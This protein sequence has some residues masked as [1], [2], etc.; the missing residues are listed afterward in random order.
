VLYGGRA[1]LTA[2]VVA[3]GLALLLGV[4]LGLAAGYFGGHVDAVIMRVMDA[5]LSFPALVLALAITAALGPN[6]SH[7]LLA[8]GIVATPLFARLTRGQALSVRE[9][10]FVLAA[11]AVGAGPAR[12]MVRHILPNVAAPLIVQASLSIPLAIL[13]E[14]SL[15][16]LGL[17]VQ[18]PEPSW[19]GMVNAGKDYLDLA[20]WM[21]FAPGTAILLTVMG[22]NF[23]GDGIRDALDPRLFIR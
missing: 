12:I 6:L 10:E 16:F 4:P 22:F 2:G 8:I 5:L 23:L 18:P 19:G 9:R 3:V 11:R 7:A 1:S 20:P 17:G 21:A 15:S 14:A 13:A